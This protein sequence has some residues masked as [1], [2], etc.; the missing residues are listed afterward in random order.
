MVHHSSTSEPGAGSK[1]EAKGKGKR[2]ILDHILV[3]P[4]PYRV[5]VVREPRDRRAWEA[6]Q[7]LVDADSDWEAEQELVEA[8][9]EEDSP[10]RSLPIMSRRHAV[11]HE[12]KAKH[13][14]KDNGKRIR[15]RNAQQQE[16]DIEDATTVLKHPKMRQLPMQ[17]TDEEL[18][19][20]ILPAKSVVAH[21]STSNNAQSLV[22]NG[23]DSF[24]FQ[25]SQCHHGPGASKT[26]AVLNCLGLLWS[27]DLESIV[28]P[29]MERVVIY[30]DINNLIGVNV[31]ISN[32]NKSAAL[33]HLQTT[34]NL[35]S[36]EHQ[37]DLWERLHRE[38]TVDNPINGLEAPKKRYK[39]NVCK[40]WF[41]RIAKHKN[42][43]KADQAHASRMFETSSFVGRFTIRLYR[44]PRL[45]SLCVP[46]QANWEPLECELEPAN[47]LPAA[48]PH[49][50]PIFRQLPIS[51]NH[52]PPHITDLGWLN[53]LCSLD[54]DSYPTL[55]SLIEPPSL[56]SAK[57]FQPR[58]LRWKVER[59]LVIIKKVAKFYILDADRQLTNAHAIV[60]DAVTHN[61]KGV[62]HSPLPNTAAYYA[63]II[64][65]IAALPL[66]WLCDDIQG[67][68]QLGS[69]QPLWAKDEKLRILVTSLFNQI[70][71]SKSA[72][73]NSELLK[74]V[75]R[76]LVFQFTQEHIPVDMVVG[77][78]S[79]Q[80]VLL[81]MINPSYGWKSAAFLITNILS[82]L[83]NIARAI[84]LHCA[85][86]NS[87]EKVYEPSSALE[88]PLAW[89]V[90]DTHDDDSE[91]GNDGIDEGDEVDSDS[92]DMDMDEDSD[93]ESEDDSESVSGLDGREDRIPAD[94]AY[95]DGE[96]QDQD[97]LHP[98]SDLS[99]ELC[100]DFLS[101]LIDATSGPGEEVQVV[102]FIQTNGK[103]FK[104]M[105]KG[106]WGRF[107]ALWYIAYRY[108]KLN[109]GATHVKWSDNGR[110]LHFNATYKS[111][112]TLNFHEFALEKRLAIDNLENLLSSL[113]PTS[114]STQEIQNI[115]VS[116]FTDN[117]HHQE[118]LFARLDNQKFLRPLIVAL[119]EHLEGMS[120]SK[121]IRFLQKCQ[122][123]LQEFVRCFYGPHGVPPRAG[124]TSFLQFSPH[125]GFP[126]NIF[127]IESTVVIGNLRAKQR[128]KRNY[129]AYWALPE[130]IG[131]SILVYL[132]IVRE[133]EES[134]ASQVEKLMQIRNSTKRRKRSLEEMKY[135]VFTRPYTRSVSKESIC[136]TGKMVNKALG[137]MEARVY[138]H[139]MKAFIRKHLHLAMDWIITNVQVP[140]D[141]LKLQQVYLSR[142]LHAFFRL[143]E[144]PEDPTLVTE[145]PRTLSDIPSNHF[146]QTFFIARYLVLSHYGLHG[147]QAKIR[148][149]CSRIKAALPFIHGELGEGMAWEELGDQVLVRVT[150]NLIY[151]KSQP[152]F[153]SSPPFNGYP[154]EIISA[155]AT[156]IFL[157]VDEWNDGIISSRTVLLEGR[158]GQS[159]CKQFLNA[160]KNFKMK[161]REKW[162][163]FSDKVFHDSMRSVGI[164]EPLE[165]V[166]ILPHTS[167]I[168]L[169]GVAELQLPLLQHA[170]TTRDLN[171]GKGE[172]RGCNLLNQQ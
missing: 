82:P 154:E 60:K 87:F 28:Q 169:D 17:L 153:L 89:E 55:L 115:T 13:I 45:V 104:S 93:N 59:T 155:A 106:Q 146:K 70:Q 25:S 145:W 48:I 120:K 172:L 44:M 1:T 84:L 99:E 159:L 74:F 26:C 38:K 3:P 170:G 135:Y 129:E 103:I 117:P 69:F 152:S 71:Q 42:V 79:E 128:R 31:S 97:P 130:R 21:N 102:R 126:R 86:L 127:V 90:C 137:N 101:P 119:S 23:P 41:E 167:L 11:T 12:A 32:E 40:K 63:Q 109:N 161:N 110:I 140:D 53:Y 61:S 50:L 20:L 30:A 112:L 43:M 52:I 148:Q 91:S 125:R 22:A 16:S 18:R 98:D 142:A 132:G 67:N 131:R 105:A 160:L 144:T 95:I 35:I 78:I 156:L 10:K 36:T 49:Q 5:K 66:R 108:A 81:Y 111:H 118:S 147:G 9:S 77:S 168:P 46:L 57:L 163:A 113:F 80:M 96:G 88:L 56:L 6:E 151:G 162:L 124:Q 171:Q 29:N 19:N 100:L 34:Y 14:G 165:D 24:I 73:P 47:T 158:M 72:V 64:S 114:F 68:K 150:S 33:S 164:R 122:D 133:A 37:V 76:F 51:S 85:F 143:V 83:K 27:E 75:H 8:D 138:R 15:D 166:T 149:I 92:D 116:S 54:V 123:F 139:I 58:S 62:Y 39:C 4:L 121:K 7:E 141:D 136:W 94:P 157:A 65:R 107:S 2:I 134:L